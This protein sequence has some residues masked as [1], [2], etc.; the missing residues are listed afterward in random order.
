MKYF[1]VISLIH[2]FIEV[3][4]AC[5]ISKGMLLNFR[6]LPNFCYDIYFWYELFGNSRDVLNCYIS[7]ASS[8]GERQWK[9]LI[10]VLKIICFFYELPILVPVLLLVK[11]FVQGELLLYLCNVSTLGLSTCCLRV[12]GAVTLPFQIPAI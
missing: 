2:L 1:F 10:D 5:D 8:F 12:K 6:Y 7:R 9:N 3:T 11:E 4:F